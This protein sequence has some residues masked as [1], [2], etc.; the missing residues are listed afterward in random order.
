[1]L[2]SA[3][4][5]D[6]H[7]TTLTRH[8][9]PLV[10]LVLT[11]CAVARKS[12]TPITNPD[13]YFHLRIGHEFLQ[14][15]AP[16]APGHVTPFEHEHWLPTQWLSQII[17]ALV[18]D[19]TGLAGIAWVY[20]SLYILFAG[21]LFWAARRQAAL[22]TA[23][24]LVPVAVIACWPNITPRPQVVSFIL[25]TVTVAVWQRARDR[26]SVPW[27]LVPM[28]WVWAMLHGMWP[29]GVAVSV[30]A[31]IGIALDSRPPRA[32]LAKLAAVPVLSLLVAGLTPVGPRLYG[33]VL[34]VNSRNEFFSE[35]GPPDFRSRQAAMLL[36]LLG[37]V[38]VALVKAPRASWF[39][40]MLLLG[41]LACSVYSQRT[42]PVAI[43][44]LVPLAASVA[45]VH[46]RTRIQPT[47]RETI[48]VIA[49]VGVLLL[50][51]AL[52][53]PHTSGDELVQPT[54]VDS[55][56]GGLPAGTRVLTEMSFGSYLLWK[57]PHLEPVT[58]GYADVYTES[59]L[60][61]RSDLERVQPRWD[62]FARRTGARIALEKTDSAVTYALESA[63]WTDVHHNDD[64]AVLIAPPDWLD[65]AGQTS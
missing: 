35:W 16:W 12:A 14:G 36:L 29:I 8:A 7:V 59:E 31:V 42:V 3:R 30:A 63:G 53:V 47:R 48:G 2:Q 41:G 60:R 24:I 26:G 46:L 28:T 27:L 39:D 9:I 45:E 13:T 56:I 52:A 65:A 19:G 37:L 58:H 1:M 40:L 62:V 23:A 64:V 50:G 25:V 44:I 18:E 43:A 51:L 5:R 32:R 21:T 20:G 33:A 17:M 54:W 4:A 38:V 6:R 22:L 61:D 10:V 57:Y 34:L 11:M 55:E 49:A 15:W